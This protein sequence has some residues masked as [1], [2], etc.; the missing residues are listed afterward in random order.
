MLMD[1]L[2]NNYHE[3]VEGNHEKP[4]CQYGQILFTS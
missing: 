2:A 3:N 1:Y 4:Y